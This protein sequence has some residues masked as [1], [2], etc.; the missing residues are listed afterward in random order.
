MRTR[1]IVGQ[2]LLESIGA[3][4]RRHSPAQGDVLLQRCDLS[5]LAEM[6][7]FHG[8]SS[9]VY[10]HMKDREFRDVSAVHEL[11]AS[12]HAAVQR[13]LFTL[14]DIPF[15]T[16]ALATLPAPWLVIKGP[17][18][19]EVVY[20][21]P[22]LRAYT[23]LDLVV[24][25]PF[26]G[27]ALSLL[28]D[29]GCRVIDDDWR[30][31][32]EMMR[33]ELQVLL[34]SGTLVDLHWH[35]LSHGRLRRSFDIS[36]E[37]LF[38]RRRSVVLGKNQV[39]TL[40][41]VDT[42][43]HL[44]AH[45]CFAG[46]NRLLWMKDIEQCVL[47]ETFTWDA[48]IDRAHEWS[49]GLVVG[50]LLARVSRLFPVDVPEEVLDELAPGT[51]WRLLVAAVDRMAPI[52]RATG[53]RSPS[54]MVARATRRDARSSFVELSRRATAWVKEGAPTGLPIGPSGRLR[55]AAGPTSSSEKGRTEER[56]AFLDAVARDAVA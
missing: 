6:A 17:V 50:S 9:A 47:H 49:V 18:L 12:Y 11:R 41:P 4:E 24:P 43:I 31:M 52:E 15:V 16:E 33:G 27:E 53:R 36:M 2:V 55:P 56:I 1:A 14:R 45:G 51:S 22:D 30:L 46:G 28:E 54:R 23:D 20:R 32:R 21:R 44:A 13:H 39:E 34:P 26:L 3:G 25:G 37:G 7:Q 5:G 29:A 10:L 40:G 8:V 35:L 42:L 48:V 38:A 19:S